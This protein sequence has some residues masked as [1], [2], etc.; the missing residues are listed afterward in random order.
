VKRPF[1]FAVL[2]APGAALAQTPDAPPPTTELFGLPVTY[3]G[4]LDA[5][6]QGEFSAPNRAKSRVTVFSDAELQLYVNHGE[7]FSLNSDIKLERNRRDNI[8][9]YF[10]DRDSAF[11]SDTLTLRQ[12]YAT[13]RPVDALDL[14][15]GK[16]HPKFGSA[17]AQLPG[18]FYNFATDYEQDERIGGGVQYHFGD[19][20]PVKDLRIGIETYFLDT[21]DL[22]STLPRGPAI[23]DPTA[24]RYYKYTRGQFGPSNTGSFSSFNAYIQGGR[25]GQGLAWQASVTREATADPAGDTEFGQSV[26]AS[27]DPTGD[28]IPLTPRI[29]LTPFVEYAHFTNFAGIKSLERHYLLGGATIGFAKWELAATASLR[30][31]RGIAAGTDHQQNIS[32]TYE[33]IDGFKLGAGINH[34]TLAGKHSWTLAPA[35]A[36][37]TSF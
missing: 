15:A 18:Y 24:D 14:Y 6:L 33:I 8:N 36:Y 19:A 4:Q 35:I 30:D 37:S 9:S 3:G 26:S 29:G 23:G 1:L 20:G 22:S 17:Y 34:V 32:L 27:Y 13:F 5:K 12:L 7:W 11:R 2:L 25:K 16:I 31:S 21:S 10:P 28:G